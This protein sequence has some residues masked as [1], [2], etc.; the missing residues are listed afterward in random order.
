MTTK[1]QES[2][3]CGTDTDTEKITISVLFTAVNQKNE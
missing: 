1:V 2:S 3:P